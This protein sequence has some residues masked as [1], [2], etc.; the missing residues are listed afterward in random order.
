MKSKTFDAFDLTIES[1]VQRANYIYCGAFLSVVLLQIFVLKG[2]I[3]L[4]AFEFK[5]VQLLKHKFVNSSG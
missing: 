4:F 2:L 5:L 3:T 1:A